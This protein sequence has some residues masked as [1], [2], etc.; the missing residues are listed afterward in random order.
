MDIKAEKCKGFSNHNEQFFIIDELNII[1]MLKRKN[2]SRQLKKVGILT[3][4]E[5]SKADFKF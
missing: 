5:N 4:K 2:N 3:I 1:H